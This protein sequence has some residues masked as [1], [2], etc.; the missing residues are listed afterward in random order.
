MSETAF[1]C[2][3]I[4]DRLP[5]LYMEYSCGIGRIVFLFPH[6]TEIRCVALKYCA[7][8]PLLIVAKAYSLPLKKKPERNPEPDAL[9]SSRW[10]HGEPPIQPSGSLLP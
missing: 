6:N 3:K 7:H 5:M 10:D 4:V 9:L 1:F 2:F 8:S